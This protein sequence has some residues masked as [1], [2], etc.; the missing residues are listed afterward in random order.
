MT[1]GRHD[2]TPI[3]TVARVFHTRPVD[4]RPLPR[5]IA[6]T[7]LDTL[8]GERWIERQLG[9]PGAPEI[10]GLDLRVPRRL[11]GRIRFERVDLTEPTA[12]SVVARILSEARC[13]AV[14]HA[15]FFAR[16]HADS[17]Y[18]HELEVIGAL[19][20]MNAAAAAQV[21][22]LVVVSG[23][24]VYG[25]RPDN[26]NFLSEEHALRGHPD[27]PAVRDRVEMERLLA[28]FAR[29]HPQIVVTPLRPCWVMGPHVD[30]EAVR[31][32]ERARVTTPL[33]FDPLM[34]FVHEEDLLDAID[35]AFERDVPGPVNL[36]G[37][38][39]LPLSMLL[40]LAGKRVRAVPAALLYRL[41]YLP[42]LWR[43]GSAPAGFYDYLRF[44]WVVD[45]QRARK[46]LGWDPEYTTREAWMSFVVSRRLR[47]Y[48]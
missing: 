25:A 35:L 22:K 43:G 41:D 9:A 47:R 42:F 18:A 39:P 14:L 15:A 46:E 20:M 45:T 26:P 13:D 27:S 28:L 10:V 40:Q 33:G 48:R 34:Q 8:A 32:F 12:D 24:Q 19:H 1:G 36:A 29:R 6:V 7:G 38:G 31:H 16:P 11:E 30:S 21:R 44:L 37:E 2:S 4:P 17:S 3:D 5:S 23:A